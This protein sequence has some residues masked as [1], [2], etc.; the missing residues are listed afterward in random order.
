MLKTRKCGAGLTIGVDKKMFGITRWCSTHGC[1][2]VR[3]LEDMRVKREYDEEGNLRWC[4]KKWDTFK[5][6]MTSQWAVWNYIV[7]ITLKLNTPEEGTW[8]KKKTINEGTT[9]KMANKQI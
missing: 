1:K 6:I 3:L 7:E 8:E 9:W 4:S 5:S 2:E